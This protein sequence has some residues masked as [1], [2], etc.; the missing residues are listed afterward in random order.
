MRE[1]LETGD[2]FGQELPEFRVIQLGE[3]VDVDLHFLK[4]AAEVLAFHPRVVAVDRQVLEFVERLEADPLG[5]VFAFERGPSNAEFELEQPLL[6]GDGVEE[7]A[8]GFFRRADFDHTAAIPIGFAEFGQLVDFV[9][10][11]GEDLAVPLARLAVAADAILR[12]PAAAV[13]LPRHFG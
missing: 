3:R 5:E 7:P 9:H 4:R 6:A 10:D 8:V 1:L 13:N 2:R 12:V 11:A